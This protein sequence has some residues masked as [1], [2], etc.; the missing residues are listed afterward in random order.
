MLDPFLGI[1]S[2]AMAAQSMGIEQFRGIEI[3]AGYLKV[4]KERLAAGKA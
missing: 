3:D 4:A 1:G 2:S